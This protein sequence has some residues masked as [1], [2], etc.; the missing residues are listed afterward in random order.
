M[1]E[2]VTL[3]Q[4]QLQN[5]FRSGG[6]RDVADRSGPPFADELPD[7][8]V[9][10]GRLHLQRRE[11]S[12]RDTLLFPEEPEKEVLG[13]DVVVA[14]QAGFL[15]GQDHHP[16]SPV[17]EALEHLSRPASARRAAGGAGT[18]GVRSGGGRAHSGAVVPGRDHDRRVD[19]V[20][21]GGGNRLRRHR[22][23]VPVHDVPQ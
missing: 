1:A 6:E 13:P 4:G 3:S 22:G 18:L 7:A 9:D 21:G 23:E 2:L 19:L 14:E 17:G 11:H 5:L 20:E 15:L 12:S 8:M 16:A 10:V